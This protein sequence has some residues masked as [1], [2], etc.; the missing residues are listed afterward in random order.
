[1][2]IRDD[3]MGQSWLL[4]PDISEL[5][6]VDH[7]CYLVAAIVNGMDVDEVEKKYRSK[8]GNPAYSHRMLL[9]LVI[10]TS[11]DAVW[12]SRKIAKQANENVAKRF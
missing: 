1:M 2:A 8:P 4:P 3:K 11:A 6:P 9:R 12:S 7:I 5:I 10:M